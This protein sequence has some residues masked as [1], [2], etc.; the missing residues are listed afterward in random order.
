ML[1][2]IGLPLPRSTIGLL[3]T[4]RGAVELP[5]S[6]FTGLL[7]LASKL[8]ALSNLR[9]IDKGLLAGA[10]L[11]RREAKAR[12]PVD[13]GD[14]SKSIKI[15]RKSKRNEDEVRVGS[16]L[17][18]ANRIER[19]FVG[20][21]RLGRIFN[22]AAQPYLRPAARAKRKKVMEEIAKGTRG[23]I[24]LSIRGRR[25]RRARPPRV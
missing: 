24:R 3:L 19:G 18:Y 17:P 14:L 13:E 22:Q 8:K 6:S 2:I 5:K 7:S 11:V 16:N 20:T 25:T 9:G 23:A 1:V 4:L 15:S 10:E 12:V 21:D